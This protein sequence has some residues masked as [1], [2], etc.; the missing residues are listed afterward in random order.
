MDVLEYFPTFIR[1]KQLFLQKLQGFSFHELRHTPVRDL[2]RRRQTG[3]LDLRKRVEASE[4]PA[5]VRE[6]VL[7]VAKRTRLWR[8][9]KVAVA[10]ELLAHF[11]DGLEAGQSAEDLLN[12]FGDERA[13][14]KLIGRAK[15]RGRPVLWQA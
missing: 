2:L 6:K 1:L 13:A 15:R 7:T 4:L 12:C 3:S 8:S 9:E 11:A 10:D 14:A 5:P